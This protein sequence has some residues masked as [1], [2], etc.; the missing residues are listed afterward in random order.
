MNESYKT[1]SFRTL[2][3]TM[4]NH[5]NIDHTSQVTK[6][7]S[8]VGGVLLK[9]TTSDQLWLFGDWPSVPLYGM[10]RN[11]LQEVNFGRVLHSNLF[12][13]LV[14]LLWLFPF[15]WHFWALAWA[16]WPYHTPLSP[17]AQGGWG[18]KEAPVSHHYAHNNKGFTVSANISPDCYI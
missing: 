8:C 3:Y 13:W 11:V 1:Q 10:H 5:W 18:W 17:V 16:V 15:L 6:V 14:V 9:V 2:Q 4:D 12:L 7:S